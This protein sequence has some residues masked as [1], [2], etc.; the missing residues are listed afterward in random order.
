MPDTTSSLA[1]TFT[2]AGAVGVFV[3][4]MFL[5]GLYIFLDYKQDNNH[6]SHETEADVQLN[7]T[8]RDMTGVLSELK[9]VINNK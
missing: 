8:L 7:D 2:Q 6:I 5:F 9:T 3:C 1:K 4:F